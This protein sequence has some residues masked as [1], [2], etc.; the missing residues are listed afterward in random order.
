MKIIVLP[1]S[2]KQHPLRNA[3]TNVTGE[4]GVDGHRGLRHTER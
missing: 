2:K 4:L 1:Q 3:G